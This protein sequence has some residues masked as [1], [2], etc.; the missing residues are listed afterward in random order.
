MI[1]RWPGSVLLN[2]IGDLCSSTR[3]IYSLE[4]GGCVALQAHMQ[5]TEGGRGGGR[6]G[7]IA[8]EGVA[9]VLVAGGATHQVS[10]LLF[11]PPTTILTIA[12]GWYLLEMWAEGALRVLRF[13]LQVH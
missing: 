12:L 8:G 11:L 13:H 10:I 2:L 5:G 6:D 9:Q 4:D 3:S 7:T 1:A